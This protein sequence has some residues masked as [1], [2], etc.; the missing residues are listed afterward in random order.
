[1]QNSLSFFTESQNTFR[2]QLECETVHA[3]IPTET[4]CPTCGWDA[5]AQSGTRV[6]CPTC[7]GL[8]KT[9]VWTKYAVTCRIMWV[10][11]IRFAM[12]YPSSGIE[13]GDCVITVQHDL[14]SIMDAVMSDERAYISVNGKTL[15][16][17]S[18]NVQDVPGVVTEYEYVCNLFTIES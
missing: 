4:T 7:H 16:P 1:M 3:L 17:T 5:V 12:P 11:T 6:D 8:G 18:K 13:L 15:R 9:I 2:E 14:T 10:S